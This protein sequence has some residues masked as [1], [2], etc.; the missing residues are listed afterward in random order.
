MPGRRPKRAET[1]LPHLT[2][3]ERAAVLAKLLALRPELHEEV[4]DLATRHLQ[5]VSLDDI[6]EEVVW[7]LENVS[8]HDLAARAGRQPGRGYVDEGEAASELLEETIRPFVDD[9][10]RRAQLGLADAASQ[11]ALGTLAGLYQCREAEAGT[12]LAYAGADEAAKDLAAWVVTE[13]TKNG[14]RLPEDA[15]EELCPEW[16][17]LP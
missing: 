10:A 12:V 9:V 2:A 4:E 3:A 6:N 5:E 17:A 16:A 8:L 1:I 14:I 11:V 15:A 13:A 7:A